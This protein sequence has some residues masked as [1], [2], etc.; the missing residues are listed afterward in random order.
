VVVTRIRSEATRYR[1]N[2]REQRV[3]PYLSCE[4]RFWNRPA[5][6]SNALGPS[7]R[8]SSLLD[9]NRMRSKWAS[10]MPLIRFG[11]L[12]GFFGF[13]LFVATSSVLTL[14]AKADFMW[15]WWGGL[16]PLAIAHWVSGFMVT[17]SSAMESAMACAIISAGTTILTII[18]AAWLA[19]GV[20]PE[21]P[22]HVAVLV[23]IAASIAG[24]LGLALVAWL[25]FGSSWR[26]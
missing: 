5:A 24:L 3:K 18:V 13:A 15:L 8:A 1:L 6:K 9:I 25:R 20:G 2:G 11:L 7:E 14:V 19:Y 21:I 26:P 16:L 23:L 12:A 22:I 10:S 17:R 4:R